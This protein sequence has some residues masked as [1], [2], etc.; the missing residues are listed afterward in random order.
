MQLHGV[1]GVLVAEGVGHVSA[2]E[3]DLPTRGD[4]SD[5]AELVVG[6]RL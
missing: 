6:E 4:G 5:R 1:G 2:A 3:Q